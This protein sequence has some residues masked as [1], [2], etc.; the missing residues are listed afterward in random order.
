MREDIQL[1]DRKEA[2]TKKVDVKRKQHTQTINFNTY[3]ASET[4]NKPTYKT[5]YLNKKT[6]NSYYGSTFNAKSHG[7]DYG[8]V[9]GYHWW[10]VDNDSWTVTGDAS[11]NSFYYPNKYRI[12]VDAAGGTGSNGNYDMEYGTSINLGTPS[13][14]G[15]KFTGWTIMYDNSINTTLSGNTLT[16]GYNKTYPYQDYMTEAS[17]KIIA[18]WKDITAPVSSDTI[19]TATNP[20]KTITYAAVTAA[21]KIAET[22]WVNNDAM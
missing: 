22:P 18:N 16:I 2:A 21:G 19:L 10:K 3:G 6:Y 4:Y 15:W 1:H 12:S 7:A 11:T 13:R 9:A 8:N 17:V 20:T 5:T 14:T